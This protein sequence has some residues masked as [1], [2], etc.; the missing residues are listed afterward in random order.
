MP[1]SIAVL[2]PTRKRPERLFKSIRSLVE[3]AKKPSSLHILIAADNNDAATID[4]I[5]TEIVSYLEENNV[6]HAS[7][8]YNRQGYANLHNYYNDLAGYA[9]AKWLMVWNDD[10]FMETQSW[11]ERIREHDGRFCCLAFDTHNHHP[12]S[13]FPVVPRDW[14][15]LVGRLSNH[16]MIDSVISQHGAHRHQGPS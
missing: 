14:Y 10:A 16:Q 12:Y 4:A 9:Q 15:A 11:D 5:K 8:S 7:I 2:I 1:L 6:S 3:T 13:I